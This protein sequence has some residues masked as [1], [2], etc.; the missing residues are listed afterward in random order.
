MV[1]MVFSFMLVGCS[2]AQTNPQVDTTPP[3][4]AEQSESKPFSLFSFNFSK[5]VPADG[6]GK[7]V[8]DFVSDQMLTQS[9]RGSSFAISAFV[10]DKGLILLSNLGEM[11]SKRYSDEQIKSMYSEKKAL[12]TNN[13]AVS[14]SL[15][16]LGG[17]DDQNTIPL[18]NNTYEYFFLENEKGEYIK[19]VGQDP[20][21][22][23]TNEVS[24]I[25]EQVTIFLLFPE[26]KVTDLMKDSKQ[27][28][29]TFKGL[30]I[31]PDEQDNRIELKY[32][33]SEYYKDKF[34]D[35]IPMVQEIES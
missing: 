25:Q 9:K 3:K 22:I 16:H 21:E 13:I 33:F 29:L 26:D 23:G 8:E 34:P 4:T 11:Y 7:Q 27:L 10:M 12:L 15:I 30:K 20:S 35:L 5:K 17:Y 19:P 18:D 24:W 2:Q 32:P 31:L 14:V 28:F 1:I 6:L